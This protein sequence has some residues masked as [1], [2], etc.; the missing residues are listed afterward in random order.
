MVT[1]GNGLVG[2]AIHSIQKYYP[3]YKF[4]FATREKYDLLDEEQVK[5][6]MEEQEEIEKILAKYQ[7]FQM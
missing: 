1:G 4:Y 7:I 2:R 5:Q 6:M 3:Q